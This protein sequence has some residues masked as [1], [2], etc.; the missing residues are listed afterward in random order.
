MR[1]GASVGIRWQ[2]LLRPL[3]RTSPR[4]L[5]E[6]ATRNC[7]TITFAV[8]LEHL[9]RGP[10]WN[11]PPTLWLPDSALAE[12]TITGRAIAGSTESLPAVEVSASVMTNCLCP[13]LKPPPPRLRPVQAQSCVKPSV[14]G[15]GETVTRLVR[16]PPICLPSPLSRSTAIRRGSISNPLPHQ[17][18]PSATGGDG[19]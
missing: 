4:M 9:D 8:S 16:A 3:E 11:G 12:A 14:R 17:K 1:L 5:E 18:V 10:I 15:E 7:L 19:S 13:S 2:S 6:Y